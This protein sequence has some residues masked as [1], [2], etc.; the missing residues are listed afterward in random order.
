MKRIHEEKGVTEISPAAARVAQQLLANYTRVSIVGNHGNVAIN[1]P[2]AIQANTVTFKNTKTKSVS[3]QP[4]AGSI[5][6]AQAKA[7]YCQHMIGRY[8]EFQKADWT[9]KTN[10]STKRSTWRSSA[11]SALHGSC[12]ART[13]SKRSSRSCSRELMPPSSAS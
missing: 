11:S 5:G 6:A 12:W 13:V 7:A 8:Q 9:G 4:P 3:I 1:S 10:S 2:G